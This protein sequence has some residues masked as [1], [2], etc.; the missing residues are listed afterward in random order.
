MTITN[1]KPLVSVN[2][3]EDVLRGRPLPHVFEELS[4]RVLPSL[5]NGHSLS[6]HFDP[7]VVFRRPAHAVGFDGLA[8]C[9]PLPAPAAFCVAGGQV[10]PQHS[11]TFPASTPAEPYA[12]VLGDF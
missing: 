2:P 10:T 6:F 7:N 3:P 12:S 1:L 9:G 11:G 4:E 5:I 8:P